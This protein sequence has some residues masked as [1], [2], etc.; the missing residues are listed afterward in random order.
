MSREHLLRN[1]GFGPGETGRPSVVGRRCVTLGAVVALLLTM[2][3]PPGA[4]AQTVYNVPADDTS[5]LVTA[6]DDANSDPG[7]S[8]VNLTGGT[9]GFGAPASYRYGP[10]AFPTISGGD[11]LTIN[12]NGATIARAPL[13]P[14]FR[15]LQVPGSGDVEL[16]NLT[17]LN[18]MH[19][20]GDG[21]PGIGGGGGGGMGGAIFNRGTLA[22][23]NVTLDGNTARGG[24]GGSDD[25]E[26]WGGGGGGMGGN[27]GTGAAGGGIFESGSAGGGGG[28]MGGDGGEGSRGGGGGGG[29]NA[30]EDGAS[31]SGVG[32]GPGAGAGGSG[33]D[34]GSAGTDG[35]WGGGGGG[36]GGDVFDSGGGGGGN[37]GE[38][39]GGGGGSRGA[40]GT[41]CENGA[42]SSGGFGGGGGGYNNG[43]FGG[44]SG[45]LGSN[46]S[47]TAGFGGGLG[48]NW[49]G[50]G[51]AGFGGAIF[52]R[53]GGTVTLV[54]CTLS[55]NVSE[56]GSGGGGA[57]QSGLGKGGAIFVE[58]GGAVNVTNVTYTSNS[59]TSAGSVADDND[60]VY[61]D[62]T[63]VSAEGEGEGEGEGQGESHTADQNGD[64]EIS[65]SELLRVIQ[66]FNSSGFHCQAGTED[67][68]APGTGDTASCD[69]HASDYNP[70]D[71]AISLSELLRV[72]QF[73]NSAGYHACPSED[74]PT[75]DGFC[76]G[77]G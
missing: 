50:G 24:T 72:I 59:A 52:T 38:G 32:G 45:G 58:D 65:L 40:L 39:G 34:F 47:V 67:G 68:Y 22:L 12:G 15:F 35:G 28:G 37:G 71:W 44:G 30:T 69:P 7:D 48:D 42:T 21:G 36:G 54:D 20:G 26:G 49:N 41:C 77:A 1:M 61:G 25:G 9:Y 46:A 19:K 66:F 29:I 73:F 70:Q 17:L 11:K 33:G 27:G 55:N 51:G 75:E 10:T 60:D 18:G 6:L 56:G 64:N 4:G 14:P 63:E 8:V 53:S 74:P 5:A 13:S 43:G 3:L 2:L 16:N 23:N 31:S 62:V 76:V 57:A